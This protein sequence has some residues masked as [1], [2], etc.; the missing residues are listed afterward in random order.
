VSRS[1]LFSGYD[2]DTLNTRTFQADL[3]VPL[4]RLSHYRHILWLVDAP[5]AANYTNT[6]ITS[7]RFMNQHG[8]PNALGSYLHLGGEVWLAGG[9]AIFAGLMGPISNAGFTPIPRSI[10]PL[11]GRF[12]YDLVHWR[13]EVKPGAGASQIRRNLGRL[14]SAPGPYAL[15]PTALQPKSLA[16]GDSMPAWR[17]SP[18]DFYQTSF[19]IEA[20]TQPNRIVEDANPDLL[21]D[22]LYSTL[23]TLYTATGGSIGS[24]VV[25]T[26]Y[27]GSDNNRLIASG[28]SLW[29]FQRAQLQQLVDG[30]L[31]G[32]WGMSRQPVAA[33]RSGAPAAWAPAYLDRR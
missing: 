30:V 22:D 28:F 29:S 19:D 15:F 26:V 6:D 32:L 5:A 12:A 21:V 20:I 7:M 18:N 4:S 23:D 11:P 27:H 17:T 2:F 16:A 25:M 8:R 10:S 33:T 24:G 3:T 14:E 1:G 13:S 9:G 31:Q